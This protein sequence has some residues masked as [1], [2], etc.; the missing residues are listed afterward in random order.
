MSRKRCPQNFCRY[1]IK[2]VPFATL[3]PDRENDKISQ[4]KPSEQ[5]QKT[6]R[7]S[8]EQALG[9][10]IF[11]IGITGVGGQRD[12]WAHF[13]LYIR[14]YIIKR[15]NYVNILKPYLRLRKT[16]ILKSLLKLRREHI[17]G[18]PFESKSLYVGSTM[19]LS[20]IAV[21]LWEAV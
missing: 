2:K 21:R 6:L 12:S 4:N 20:L 15:V 10:R 16:N 19:L 1:L 3:T 9:T 8:S 7:T 11:K 17:S 18:F 5:E 13:K 14:E